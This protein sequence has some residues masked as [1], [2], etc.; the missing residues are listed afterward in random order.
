MTKQ[1]NMA[2]TELVVDSIRILKGDGLTGAGAQKY[3][4]KLDTLEQKITVIGN[5]QANISAIS[6]D[7]TITS[8]EKQTLKKEVA[9]IEAE[10]PI[11]TASAVDAEVS[12]YPEYQAYINAYNNLKDYLNNSLH[13]FDDMDKLT[14]IT[15]RSQFNSYFE[16][17]YTARQSLND[18]IAKGYALSLSGLTEQNAIP[19]AKVSAPVVAVTGENEYNPGYI[20]VQAVL[21]NGVDENIYRAIFRIFVN[22]S[23][24][25]DYESAEAEH[26]INYTIKPD[27]HELRV[28]MYDQ[29][30]NTIYDNEPIDFVY[31]DSGNTLHLSNK[32]QMFYNGSVSKSKAEN[33]FFV[34]Q[35]MGYNGTERRPVE[36]GKLPQTKGL[37]YRIDGDKIYISPTEEIEATGEAIFNAYIE[38]TD[39]DDGFVFGIGEGE[40]AIVIGMPSEEPVLLGEFEGQTE[41]TEFKY[42][43]VEMSVLRENIRLETGKYLGYYKDYTKL[44]KNVKNGDYILYAGQSV[45]GSIWKNGLTYQYNGVYWEI[46][47]NPAHEMASISDMWGL[48]KELE[49]SDTAPNAMALLLIKN[50]VAANAYLTNLFTKNVRIMNGGSFCSENWFNGGGNIDENGIITQYSTDG[51]AVDTNGVIDAV[52]MHATDST[53][54]GNISAKSFCISGIKSGDHVAYVYKQRN[55]DFSPSVIVKSYFIVPNLKA[56]SLSIEI[57]VQMGNSKGFNFLY[58]QQ[59]IW[60]QKNTNGNHTILYNDRGTKIYPVY[61][62]MY[63]SEMTDKIILNFDTEDDFIGIEWWYLSENGIEVQ[64]DLGIIFY[65]DSF[66][67][68]IIHNIMPIESF[69]TS[70]L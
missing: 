48:M 45:D 15:S 47:N 17:Y 43:N 3:E 66:H 6:D 10:E 36:V 30:G 2:G 11:I 32:Y 21:Q 35:V 67:P 16:I 24:V 44:P 37:S 39:I 13:L 33:V 55:V 57:R 12:L 34:T 61:S 70:L 4:R 40:N 60:K 52:N 22:G 50:L 68:E 19:V 56:S 27:T 9:I 63:F 1:E 7:H 23:S 58:R 31:P 28:V 20:M 49:E 41:E 59:C 62:G 29:L 65:S 38:N 53:F 18:I 14:K 5:N 26:I 51:F 54:E 69:K 8:E 25:P 64:P 42:E 46:D